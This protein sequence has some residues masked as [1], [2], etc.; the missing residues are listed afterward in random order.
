MKSEIL[1]CVV[2]AAS[3]G[4]GG[5]WLG[6]RYAHSVAS[7]AVQP[8]TNYLA[9]RK[10][11]PMPVLPP[12]V[13][14]T[15]GVAIAV[16]KLSLADVVAKILELKKKGLL[17]FSDD[18]YDGEQNLTKLLLAIDAADIPAV[19]TF[20]DKNLSKQMRWGFRVGLLPRW[21]GTDVTAAMAYADAL[22]DRSERESCI[23]M[24]VGV[25]AAKDPTS[26]AAWAK[27]IPKGQLRDQVVQA[28]VNALAEKDPAAAL[29]LWQS[30]AHDGSQRM[31]SGWGASAQIFAPGRRKIR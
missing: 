17:G 6:Q 15:N 21:A 24:V 4:G 16:A 19:L 8:V 9:G 25:W 22:P 3:V 1:F 29:A 28:V 27:Q 13:A 26:A 14:G 18:G 2:L 11:P 20:V 30:L 23:S 7:A 31:R 10:I 12:T 5:F